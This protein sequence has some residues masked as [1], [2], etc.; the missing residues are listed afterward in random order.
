M[1]RNPQASPGPRP[2]QSPRSIAAAVAASRRR[3]VAWS[4]KWDRS[5]LMTISVSGPPQSRRRTSATSCG[6]ASPTRSG[7]SREGARAQSAGRAAPPRA[8][9]RARG[10]RPR[11]RRSAGRRGPT[12]T[13]RSTGT[14]PSGV[15]KASARRR[16]DPAEGGVVR[17][18]DHHHAPDGLRRLLPE[19]R[20]GGRGDRAGIGVAGVRH[21]Q[22]LGA[23]PG[24]RRRLRPGQQL[25]DLGPQPRRV[26]GIEQARH[27]GRPHG[28]AFGIASAPDVAPLPSAPQVMVG[29][30]ERKPDTM[31]QDI[32]TGAP[33][34]Y[35][36]RA[37]GRAHPVRP[38][39]ALLPAARGPARPVL[40]ARAPRRPRW[41]SRPTAARPASA[42]TR[43]RRSRSTISCPARRCCRSA[44]RAAT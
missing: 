30:S 41:C 7:T 32:I 38:V 43:S 26:R 12:A 14:R 11:A 17:R 25:R 16:G 31:D 29:G 3:A 5:E 15:S 9:A 35:W 40:R 23:E 13:R 34:R 22:R 33:G 28:R 27:G 44:P 4:W 21:D 42:S 39:P 8:R 2:A 19:R 18:P 20:E 6:S 1:A 10:V 37:R 24:G 36:H